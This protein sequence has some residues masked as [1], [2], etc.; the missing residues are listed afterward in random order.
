M[1]TLI[2]RYHRFVTIIA[3]PDKRRDAI[4]SN[5]PLFHNLIAKRTMYEILTIYS[6]MICQKDLLTGVRLSGN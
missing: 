6:S 1:L 4:V 5:V 2:P 3:I